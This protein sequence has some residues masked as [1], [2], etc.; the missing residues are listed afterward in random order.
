MACSPPGSSVHGIFQA[1]YWSGLPFPS[2]GNLPDR[3][4][5]PKSSALAGGFFTAE[6]PGKSVELLESS[7][8]K[9]LKA[10]PREES[11][12][13]LQMQWQRNNSS[14]AMENHS[15]VAPHTQNKQTKH[16]NSPE[17]KLQVMEYCDPTNRGFK[18]AVTEKSN[19]LQ[20]S[21]ERQFNKLRNKIKEQT[22][23]C[24]KEIETLKKNKHYGAEKF[25]K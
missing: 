22:E 4:M 18:T 12:S 17:T 8:E 3:G 1:E 20:E 5:E 23:Y 21:S 7:L 6:P 25:N 10:L 2:P 14:S 15:N 9:N 24:T 13:Q 19:E 11:C 16:D